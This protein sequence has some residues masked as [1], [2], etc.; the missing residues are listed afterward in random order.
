M[1]HNVLNPTLLNSTEESL[2]LEY[3]GYKNVSTRWSDVIN[4]FYKKNGVHRH[5]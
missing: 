4:E 1:N 2:L 3:S 5:D